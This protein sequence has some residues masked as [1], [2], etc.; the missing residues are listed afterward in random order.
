MAESVLSFIV[1]KLGDAFVREVLQLHG[2]GEQ[3]ERVRRELSRI[4]AFLK[5]T[6]KKHIVDER[7]KQWV[8]EVRDLA[9]W[10]EDVVDTFLTE[11]LENEPGKMG[12]VKRWFTGTTK[13][14]TIHRLG[15]EINKIEAMI[16]EIAESRLRYGITN[17]GESNEGE[18]T[19]PVRR[20]VLPDVDEDGIVGFEVDRDKIVN[21][22]LDEKTTKRS[23]I[24][25]VGPGGLGKTTLA[26]KVYNRYKLIHYY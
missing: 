15:H 19:L 20:I 26:R 6:D 22:L 14:P 11:V 21:L 18:I 8:K 23:V 5:D 3:V 2:V 25:I 24:S 10:I 9:Y 4:Q 13:L 7:Q 17:I 16:E 12:A 1:G